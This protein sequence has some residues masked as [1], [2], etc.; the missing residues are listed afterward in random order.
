MS[1]GGFLKEC[2]ALFH[3]DLSTHFTRRNPFSQ[4]GNRFRKSLQSLRLLCVEW[5]SPLV[6][7]SATRSFIAISRSLSS[8][9]KAT[10]DLAIHRSLLV[11]FSRSAQK[12]GYHR[13]ILSFCLSCFLYTIVISIDQYFILRSICVNFPT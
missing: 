10:P 5:S 8:S 3:E 13:L 11:S 1:V 4:G 7:R 9:H 6:C 2:C 12:A